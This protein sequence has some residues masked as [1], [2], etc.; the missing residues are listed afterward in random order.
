L[1]F[2]EKGTD[3][4]PWEVGS[5]DKAAAD[6]NAAVVAAGKTLKLS[7]D[8]WAHRGAPMEIDIEEGNDTRDQL[9]SFVDHVRRRDVQTIA[10]ATVG[11]MDCATVLMANQSVETGGWVEFPKLS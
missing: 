7:N 9:V 2:Q 4:V 3:A 11:M 6:A 10:D 5:K 1:L 8:P